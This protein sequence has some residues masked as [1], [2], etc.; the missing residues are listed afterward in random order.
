MDERAI[1]TFADLLAG[2]ATLY[3]VICSAPSTA[4]KDTCDCWEKCSCGWSALKG[5]PCRNPATTRCSTKVK[6]GKYNRKT[7][8]YE[9]KPSPPEGKI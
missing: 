8:R 3:C 6:Y 5:E 2:R 4:G 9:K 7:R 1:N